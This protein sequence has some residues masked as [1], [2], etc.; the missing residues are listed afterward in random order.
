MKPG[1]RVT[2]TFEGEV[3]DRT[4]LRIGEDPGP[5]VPVRLDEHCWYW[6]PESAC[7]VIEDPW[8]DGD[9][10]HCEGEVRY[11]HEGAWRDVHGTWLLESGDPFVA[12]GYV[13][14]IRGGKMIRPVAE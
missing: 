5:V 7:T 6:V 2:V 10:A 9:V 12:E 1:D 4:R 14:I 3:L 8:Q 11:L 13:P